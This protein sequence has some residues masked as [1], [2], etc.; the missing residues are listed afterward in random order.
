MESSLLLERLKHENISYLVIDNNVSIQ[1]CLNRY[2]IINQEV[3]GDIEPRIFFK[4][5]IINETGDLIFSNED[6]LDENYEHIISEIHMFKCIFSTDS[7][8]EETMINILCENIKNKDY[9]NNFYENITCCTNFE[10]SCLKN[11]FITFLETVLVE[12]NI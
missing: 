6:I 9:I 3:F 7:S 1:L 12:Q 2:L 4:L 5:Y 11:Q 8:K 10:S